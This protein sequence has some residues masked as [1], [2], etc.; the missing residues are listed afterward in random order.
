MRF[1]VAENP[2]MK[3]RRPAPSPQA[4]STPWLSLILSQKVND[5]WWDRDYCLA[6]DKIRVTPPEATKLAHRAAR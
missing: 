6:G 4:E 1:M 5:D 2:V 3:R